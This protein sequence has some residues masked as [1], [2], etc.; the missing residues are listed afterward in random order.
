M[1]IDTSLFEIQMM[2]LIKQTEMCAVI[3]YHHL[4]SICTN[5]KN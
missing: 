5:I 2:N 3:I 1:R 4:V